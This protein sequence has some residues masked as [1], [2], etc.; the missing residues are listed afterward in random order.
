M[1]TEPSA[2]RWFSRNAINI[3]GGT[4]AVPPAVLY[5]IS[6]VLRGQV[7]DLSS[8]VGSYGF[9]NGKQYVFVDI[10]KA[11]FA[12]LRLRMGTYNDVSTTMDITDWF[13]VEITGDTFQ[14]DQIGVILR[15]SF[16]G[17]I[18]LRSSELLLT[19]NDGLPKTLAKRSD[20]PYW[21]DAM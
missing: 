6:A 8:Y 5:D 9:W 14:Y 21:W 11:G 12:S 17:S 7:R 3:L 16:K 10:D 20:Y 13:S 19:P 18:T 4:S 15:R 2:C 1:V